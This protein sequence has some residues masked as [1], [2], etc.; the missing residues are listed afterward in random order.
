MTGILTT[1]KNFIRMQNFV[2]NKNNTPG[3][4]KLERKD[5]LCELCGRSTTSESTAVLAS[6]VT[7]INT[8]QNDNYIV[9]HKGKPPKLGFTGT[10]S[11]IMTSKSALLCAGQLYQSSNP[12]PTSL[13]LTG[14]ENLTPL[15]NGLYAQNHI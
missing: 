1:S 5:V 11:G 13:T 12:S 14:P 3:L 4:Q 15:C 10:V 6:G 7:L 2:G 9:R 8:K